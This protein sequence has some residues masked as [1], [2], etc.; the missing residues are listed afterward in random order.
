MAK[1]TIMHMI[2]KNKLIIYITPPILSPTQ[3]EYPSFGELEMFQWG[4][5]YGSGGYV[6][7][8]Y[9]LCAVEILLL[10]NIGITYTLFSGFSRA[11]SWISPSCSTACPAIASASCLRTVPCR[12][13]GWRNVPSRP[14][15]QPYTAPGLQKSRPP[16]CTAGYLPSWWCGAARVFRYIWKVPRP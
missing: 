1:I 14:H 3:F 8:S 2:F 13:A 7:I 15:R 9:Y 5:I 10:H 6:W 12:T 16:G 11:D 4:G